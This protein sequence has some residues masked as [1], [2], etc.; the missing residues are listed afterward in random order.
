MNDLVKLELERQQAVNA[1]LGVGSS[2]VASLAAENIALREIAA[3]KRMQELASPA[4][5]VS[6]AFLDASKSI[7]LEQ[8]TLAAVDFADTYGRSVVE[9]LKQQDVIERQISIAKFMTATDS[10]AVQ[11]LAAAPN[12]KI[13]D[14]LAAD[15]ASVA[16]AWD[17]VTLQ[18]HLASTLAGLKFGLSPSLED[19][20]GALSIKSVAALALEERAGIASML[21]RS[22][23]KS[24]AVQAVEL[25]LAER[26]RAV[27]ESSAQLIGQ[28][29]LTDRFTAQLFADATSTAALSDRMSQMKMPW[30]SMA[31]EIR[32][33][34]AFA[35]VQGL[36]EIVSHA[37]PYSTAVGSI[38]RAGGMG[39]WRANVDFGDQEMTLNER[40]Q[41][42]VAHGA[43]VQVIEQE[44]KI[45]VPSAGIAGLFEEDDNWESSWNIA[46]ED[47]EQL[48]ILAYERLRKLERLLRAFVADALGDQFGPKWTKQRLPNGTLDSCIARQ[49]ASRGGADFTEDVTAY[50]DFTD[51]GKII[52]RGDN[53]KEV[54]RSVFGRR[55]NIKESLQ[56]LQPLRLA[57]MHARSVSSF[58]LL[59]L[60]VESKRIEIAIQQWRLGRSRNLH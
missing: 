39:D 20:I 24:A 14:S 28:V 43:D 37:A 18:D 22:I 6:Q 3:V 27:A 59:I 1:A 31:D 29:K 7:A 19:R 13:A 56:R 51:Y 12:L 11:A 54:F 30:L 21:D 42:Y 40:T 16:K 10:S 15:F 45:F 35:R 5:A 26:F 32:S 57:T 36:G 49:E 9:K 41:F 33:A 55:E 38:L 23:Y 47:N 48:A 60:F 50:L 17:S 46:T 52:D 53:W 8:K 44:T 34:T 58:D 2:A 4:S 25:G